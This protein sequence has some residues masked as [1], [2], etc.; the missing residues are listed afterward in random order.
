MICGFHQTALLR[1][2]LM[3][4]T[5]TIPDDLAAQVQ[6]RGLTP[7]SYVERLIAEQAEAVSKQ[8]DTARRLASLDRFIERMAAHSDKIPILPDVALTRESF[9][10]D[11]D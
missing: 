7:E 3:Q 8:A 11:H 10:Q 4:I 5:V 1:F 9:Y 6:A 2:T